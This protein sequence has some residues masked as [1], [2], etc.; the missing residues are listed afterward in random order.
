MISEDDFRLALERALRA[1]RRMTRA[2]RINSGDVIVVA[3]GG[4]RYRFRGAPK[5]TGDLWGVVKPFGLHLEV[6]VKGSKGKPRA[7]QKRRKAWL[8][9]M[10]GVY[11][12]AV[13]R[14]ETLEE[15]VAIALREIDAAIAA[16]LESHATIR[17][18]R[19]CS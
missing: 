13:P 12:V 9:L 14:G 18:F 19:T 5:G 8:E 3:P 2:W 11:V 16:A 1:P 17:S 7:A 6:E 15:S 4:A 10:G